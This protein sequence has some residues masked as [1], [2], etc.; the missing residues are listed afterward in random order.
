MRQH[1]VAVVHKEADSDFRDTLPG[2][3]WRRY[4][5]TIKK[6]GQA[7]ALHA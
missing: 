1:Y 5:R 2:L 6:G 7:L 4:H 3:P